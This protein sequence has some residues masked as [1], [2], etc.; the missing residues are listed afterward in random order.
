VARALEA[1]KRERRKTRELKTAIGNS[2]EGQGR[3]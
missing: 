3:I 1:A 2:K